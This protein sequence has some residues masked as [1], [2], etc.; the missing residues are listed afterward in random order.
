MATYQRMW[1][2][3]SSNPEVF[4]NSYEEG[5]DRVKKGGYAFLMES[6]ALDYK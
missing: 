1:A 2:Y 5:V 6:A 4:V 3:M